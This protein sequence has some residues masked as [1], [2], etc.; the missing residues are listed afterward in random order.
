MRVGDD[1]LMG[2]LPDQPAAGQWWRHRKG[3]LY[4]VV[5]VALTEATQEPV[6]VYRKHM[7]G[8]TWVRPVEEFLDGRFM[9]TRS[10]FDS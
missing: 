10:P 6:V 2:R 8:L 9:P 7:V 3:G 5:C 1:E 4:Q